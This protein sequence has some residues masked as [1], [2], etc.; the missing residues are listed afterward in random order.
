MTDLRFRQST[1]FIDYLLIIC[2]R[3]EL[4]VSEYASE[5]S[6]LANELSKH[7]GRP[8]STKDLDQDS[9]KSR[10]CSHKWGNFGGWWFK[11]CYAVFLNGQIQKGSRGINWFGKNGEDNY[12][13]SLMAIKKESLK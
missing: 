5:L 7:N 3:Y 6:T 1:Y 10:S 4:H 2:F 12:K 11:H 13:D 8:F 9:Y